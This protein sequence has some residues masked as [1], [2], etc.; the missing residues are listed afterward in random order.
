MTDYVIALEPDMRLKK[1]ILQLKRKAK[2][3]AGDQKYLADAPHC[4]LMVFNVKDKAALMKEL[5]MV[6]DEIIAPALKEGI[7]PEISGWLVFSGDVI[8]GNETLV[9][10]LGKKCEKKLAVMQQKA[11]ARISKL[12]RP[13]LPERYVKASRTLPEGMRKDLHKYGYPFVGRGWKPHISIASFEK[14]AFASVYK[15]LEKS[16]PKGKFRFDALVLYRLGGK[17]K[18]AMLKRYP[19]RQNRKGGRR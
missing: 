8:T 14:A 17:E 9:C 16:C 12:R 7:N 10:G 2:S 6:R 11:V 4:T 1:R 3:I 18:L 5:A 19:L 13:K 15:A